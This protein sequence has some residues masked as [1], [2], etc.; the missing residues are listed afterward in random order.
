[1]H[2]EDEARLTCPRRP[3]ECAH[4]ARRHLPAD[5]ALQHLQLHSCT[6]A[7]PAISSSSGSTQPSTYGSPDALAFSPLTR[8]S[9][10]CC[11]PALPLLPHRPLAAPAAHVHAVGHVPEEEHPRARLLRQQAGRALAEVGQG[12]G[13]RRRRH[14]G[15]QQG[16][17]RLCHDHHSSSQRARATHG[18]QTHTLRLCPRSQHGMSTYC[19]L[20]RRPRPLGPV[21]PRR[22]ADGSSAPPPPLPLLLS[23][24]PERGALAASSAQLARRCP[25]CCC[26]GCSGA[27]R[28]P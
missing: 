8:S 22:P 21:P 28:P 7:K 10:C 19:L 13:R 5:A 11:C 6:H 25:P 12:Q 9:V 16:R 15:P 27:S 26:P 1:M 17:A 20:P 2:R 24:R 23:R 14:A 18:C 3:H 4:L